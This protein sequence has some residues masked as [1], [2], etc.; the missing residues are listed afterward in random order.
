MKIN[1]IQGMAADQLN[2]ELQRGGRFV[3][4]QYAISVIVMSFRRPFGGV[5][6][7]QRREH[8]A[9]KHRLHAAD[10]DRR[11]VGNSVWADFHDSVG[12][13]QLP[14]RQGRDAAGGGRSE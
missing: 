13:D 1:G 4:F 6:H 11:L 5:L 3:V 2:F 10:S 14:W 12:G 7:P 8:G 9:E